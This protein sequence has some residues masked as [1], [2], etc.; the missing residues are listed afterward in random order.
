MS[1]EVFKVADRETAELLNTGLDDDNKV[2]FINK[3]GDQFWVR[4]DA[5]M[6]AIDPTKYSSITISQDDVD[7]SLP[8]TKLRRI[9]P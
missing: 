5:D 2:A 8:I 7:G 9:Y 6:S 4:N 3:S 1:Y